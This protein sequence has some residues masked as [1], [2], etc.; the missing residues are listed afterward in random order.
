MDHDF[1]YVLRKRETTTLLAGLLFPIQTPAPPGVIPGGVYLQIRHSS[2][3]GQDPLNPGPASSSP[4]F[5]AR[6]LPQRGK[7]SRRVGTPVPGV[8][9]VKPV[10]PPAG[11][12]GRC[13]CHSSKALGA[14]RAGQLPPRGIGVI[15]DLSVCPAQP[16]VLSPL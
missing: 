8:V 1:S 10:E 3:D 7:Q 11:G 15:W 9:P 13:F 2:S 16:A 14:P 12:A 6:L 5:C 4:T